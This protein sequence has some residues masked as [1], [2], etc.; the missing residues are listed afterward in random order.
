MDDDDWL[1]FVCTNSEYHDLGNRCRPADRA[2]RT[3][4]DKYVSCHL[5][6]TWLLFLSVDLSCRFP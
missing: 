2:V 6:D 5:R 1:P 4:E 3:A